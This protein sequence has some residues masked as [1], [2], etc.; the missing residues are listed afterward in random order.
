LMDNGFYYNVNP[1]RKE[2]FNAVLN[3]SE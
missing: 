1:V 2:I 3:Y